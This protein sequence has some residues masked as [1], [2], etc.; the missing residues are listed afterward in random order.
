MR[1]AACSKCLGDLCLLLGGAPRFCAVPP[2]IGSLQ[3][4]SPRPVEGG[5]DTGSWGPCCGRRLPA[6]THLPS[7]V[8]LPYRSLACFQSARGTLAGLHADR[9]RARC[10]RVGRGAHPAIISRRPTAAPSEQG[11]LALGRGGAGAARPARP[12]PYL[13]PSTPAPGG[14][15]EPVLRCGLRLWI[16]AHLRGEVHRPGE[17]V[18]R[19]HRQPAL[20]HAP[21]HNCGGQSTMAKPPLQCRPWTGT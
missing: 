13:A 5:W 7:E 9:G 8:F 19:R 1:R 17:L 12:S 18:L 10:G 15:W 4:G 14:W 20:P 16:A 3:V 2:F 11:P 6:P 21:G